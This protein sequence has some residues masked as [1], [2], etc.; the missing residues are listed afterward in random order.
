M[1]AAPTCTKCST[2]I[3]A[4]YFNSGQ[5]LPCLQCGSELRTEILPAYFREEAKGSSGEALLI[6]SEASCF[7][8]PQKRAAVICSSCGRFLCALCDLELDNAHYCSNCLEVAKNKGKIA[9]IENT[10]RLY[11][12]LALQV[13]LL[14]FIVYFTLFTAPFAIYLAVKHWNTPSSVVRRQSKWRQVSAIII[15]SLQLIGALIAT[16]LILTRLGR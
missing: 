7:Y 8:H 3:P 5:Y 16:G 1:K 2:Q 11:D 9:G 14:G 15:A 4:D 13:A 6:D 10:R 12:T